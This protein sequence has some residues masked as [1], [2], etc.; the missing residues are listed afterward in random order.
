MTSEN[1]KLKISLIKL[2]I[3]TDDIVRLWEA[4][5][6]EYIS[7]KMVLAESRSIIRTDIKKALRLAK[8]AKTEFSKEAI[9]AVK[10]NQ[11]KDKIA[12]GDSNLRNMNVEYKRYLANG[13]YDNASSCLSKMID[14][15]PRTKKDDYILEIA[16]SGGNSTT[17][18]V[19]NNTSHIVSVE[20]ISASSNGNKVNPD[21]I[22]PF[23]LGSGRTAEFTLPCS[24][25]GLCVI[26]NLRDSDGSREIS[27]RGE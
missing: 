22:P 3:L 2:G 19:K 13:D 18:S 11:I 1:V 23:S 26:V 7:G 16:S 14:Y 4:T 17:V 12:E 21:R 24:S 10:Y 5:P 27:V 8:K 25:L 20:S 6:S 9:I 15:E